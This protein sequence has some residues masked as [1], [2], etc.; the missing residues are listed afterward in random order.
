[1]HKPRSLLVLAIALVVLAGALGSLEYGR[2]AAEFYSRMALS[3]GRGVRDRLTLH[4]S[5]PIAALTL[6]GRI[7]SQAPEGRPGPDEARALLLTNLSDEPS[8]DAAALWD[9]GG[10]SAMAVRS[11][12]GFL[13]HQRPD[14]SGGDSRWQRLGPD[15]ATLGHGAPA[16]SDIAA[17]A[18]LIARTVS[19]GSQ[20]WPRWTNIHAA[21]GGHTVIGAVAPA[22]PRG[23]SSRAV[24]FGF[25]LD[26][27]LAV[28]GQV[29]P[30]DAKV[31]VCS[32]DGYLLDAAPGGQAGASPAFVPM[33]RASDRVTAD[34]VQA[35]IKAGTPED[36]AFGFTS[37][38]TGYWASL[39]PLAGNA[40]RT[41]AGVIMSR[42]ALVS[43][44]LQGGKGPLLVAAGFALAIGLLAFIAVQLRRRSH[45]VKPFFETGDEVRE[46]LAGGESDRLEFKSTLRFNLASGKHGKEIELAAMKTLTAFMNT[47]GGILAV[48]VDDQ[49]AA[50]G[51]D[52]DGFENDDHLLRHFSSLFAQHIGVEHLPK[53]RFALR[54]A[55]ERKVLLIECAKSAE[56]V[57]LKGGKEEEFYVRAGPSSRRLSLTEFMRRIA[58]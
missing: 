26:K 5:P 16:A 46:L 41:Y 1:M 31:L 6:T 27:T 21:P 15:L 3:E 38:G 20:D 14:A 8:L 57:I 58:K 48:G 17:Q 40:G 19:T 34:A 44:L 47:D 50:L 11:G 42:E 22:G 32:P 55:D 45:G 4:L 39:Q 9:A 12:D 43:L 10:I 7:L 37:G 33:S 2:L 54:D 24:Y 29:I 51:L 18:A 35:W 13:F 56:P 23:D 30:E 25:A 28:L 36:A 49:G 52:A 53:V